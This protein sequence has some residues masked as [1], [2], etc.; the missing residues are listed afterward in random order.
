MKVVH[1]LLIICVFSLVYIVV[2]QGN[3]ITN[4]RQTIQQLLH[5]C[6]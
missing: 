1:L 2:I 6:P 5:D 4:Q 3:T